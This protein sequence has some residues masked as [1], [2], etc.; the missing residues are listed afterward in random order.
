LSF[1]DNLEKATMLSTSTNWNEKIIIRSNSFIT[2]N[3]RSTKDLKLNTPFY[4]KFEV[5]AYG[6]EKLQCPTQLR[7]TIELISYMCGSHLS[8]VYSDQHT[9]F[10]HSLL[11]SFEEQTTAA[12]EPVESNSNSMDLEHEKS[13]TNA[14]LSFYQSQLSQIEMSNKALLNENQRRMAHLNSNIYKMLFRSGLEQYEFDEEERNFLAAFESQSEDQC[15]EEDEIEKKDSSFSDKSLR[16]FL[17]SLSNFYSDFLLGLLTNTKNTQEE[18]NN[19]NISN[20]KTNNR[21]AL[22]EFMKLYDKDYITDLVARNTFAN[23]PGGLET[24]SAIMK[25]FAALI[26]HTPSIRY[27]DLFRVSISSAN[28]V[29]ISPVWNEMVAQALKAAES[30]RTL[31]IGQQQL[32]KSKYYFKNSVDCYSSSSFGP[33][34]FIKILNEK[35]EF[36]FKIKRMDNALFNYELTRSNHSYNGT[37]HHIHHE[38]TTTSF[39]DCLSSGT[40]SSYISQEQS[41]NF[42]ITKEKVNPVAA[43]AAIA[44]AYM[45]AR[46]PRFDSY[47]SF[48]LVFEFL[49]DKSLNNIELIAK[50]LHLKK[51]NA[52]LL[53]KNLSLALEFLQLNLNYKEQP[54]SNKARLELMLMYMSDFSTTNSASASLSLPPSGGEASDSQAMSEKYNNTVDIGLQTQ[55]LINTN[56]ALGT[57]NRVPAASFDSSS[58]KKPSSAVRLSAHLVPPLLKVNKIHYMQSL[59]GCGLLTENR[60]RY[61]YFKFVEFLLGENNQKQSENDRKINKTQTSVEQRL[62]TSLDCFLISLLDNDWD[63]YDWRHLRRL[64]VLDFLLAKSI[65]ST[66]LEIYRSGLDASTPSQV[67]ENIF[68]FS[69]KSFNESVKSS[70]KEVPLQ[71]Y[72]SNKAETTTKAISDC[73]S[74][75]S[76]EE[77]GAVG[78][79][80][81]KLKLAE[82]SELEGDEVEVSQN[83]NVSFDL[84]IFP[85]LYQRLFNSTSSSTQTLDSNVLIKCI[86]SEPKSYEQYEKFLVARYMLWKYCSKLKTN[87]YCDSCGI[88]LTGNRYVCLECRDYCFCFNCFPKSIVSDSSNSSTC[89]QSSEDDGGENDENGDE[90]SQKAKKLNFSTNVH[91]PTH[92][93]LLLDHICNMCSS[94]IISKR[95]HCLECDDFD[96]CQT[97]HKEYEKN[98]EAAAQP[99][100]GLTTTSITGKADSPSGMVHLASHKTTCIEPVILV[101]KPEK[102]PSQQIYLHLHSKYLFTIMALKLSNIVN[103]IAEMKCTKGIEPQLNSIMRLHSDCFG[104]ILEMINNIQTSSSLCYVESNKASSNASSIDAL[105]ECLNLFVTYS[106]ESLVGLLSAMINM[107]RRM[108]ITNK[109]D[110]AE[111]LGEEGL[112]DRLCDSIKR[113]NECQSIESLKSP[114]T[115]DIYE[116]VKFL[117]ELLANRPNYAIDETTTCMLINLISSL[118]SECEP[119]RMNQIVRRSS[120]SRK[121]NSNNRN[122]ISDSR[123]QSATNSDEFT[124]ELILSWLD[125]SIELGQMAFVSLYIGML[126]KLNDSVKWKSRISDFFTKL[127]DSA[128]LFDLNCTTA[129]EISS[130]QENTSSERNA[131]PH[132]IMVKSDNQSATAKLLLNFVYALNFSCSSIPIGQWIEYKSEYRFDSNGYVLKSN[133]GQFK[134][135]L[136]KSIC[137]E[138]NAYSAFHLWVID[139]NSRRSINLKDLKYDSAFRSLTEQSVL[140]KLNFGTKGVEDNSIVNNSIKLFNKL[141]LKYETNSIAIRNT[142][143]K[144]P[145]KESSNKVSII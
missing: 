75:E 81:S 111:Q 100:I 115:L 34:S 127:F 141:L 41:K 65:K 95:V 20:T 110:M 11:G 36:L 68:R 83:E 33:K 24:A 21:E 103:D 98:S 122:D 77:G 42:A 136:L 74:N 108:I 7:D 12:K 124:L 61:S 140:S 107:C 137:D 135:A 92:K 72:N 30:T 128:N 109:I 43:A 73:D 17:I 63:L 38:H 84:K 120:C 25:I 90:Q 138:D 37:E 27:E 56:S 82:I 2:F 69:K 45:M 47:P 144:Q 44:G 132:A 125:Q 54:S 117:L 10:P 99:V 71:S 133:S 134:V 58:S 105:K 57:I 121:L 104:F 91:K 131:S 31:I 55:Q 86:S 28:C 79:K 62:S 76:G 35:S 116:L 51:F 101:V 102:V 87:F 4:L 114:R 142:Q 94:L 89:S 29:E 67:L 129:A 32:F 18:S 66:P 143:P 64:R 1:S 3:I 14:N 22:I 130:E 19:S 9:S 96:L 88:I 106:Q 49:F 53:S 46:L 15:S 5:K 48:G 126:S 50:L 13:P 6:F 93:V 97:C 39:V 80:D 8:R 85:N 139:P 145:N 113:L 70:T 118:I 52:A 119:E 112:I 78:G 59:H 16:E 40:Q 26:W 60:L 23:K 123:A